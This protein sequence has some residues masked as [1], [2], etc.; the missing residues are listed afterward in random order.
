MTSKNNAQVVGKGGSG[1]FQ[2]FSLPMALLCPYC[3]WSLLDHEANKFFI[4]Q[5]HL[6]RCDQAADEDFGG[7]EWGDVAASLALPV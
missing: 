2:S 6:V 3:K 4:V 7:L 1:M 5:I